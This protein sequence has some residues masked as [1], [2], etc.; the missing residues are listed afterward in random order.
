MKIELIYLQINM[1]LVN[2]TKQFFWRLRVTRLLDAPAFWT[3]WAW[4]KPQLGSQIPAGHLLFRSVVLHTSMYI[5]VY[6]LV[7]MYSYIFVEFLNLNT[8]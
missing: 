6:V 3:H 1:R 2:I 4:F 7:C 8:Y 5:L